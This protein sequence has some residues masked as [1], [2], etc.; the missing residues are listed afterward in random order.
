MEFYWPGKN[1]SYQAH[2]R[3]PNKKSY[4][5]GS[6]KTAMEASIYRENYIKKIKFKE[7]EFIK[8]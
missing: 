5:L 7:L 4:Y 2:I 3:H 8:I 1:N 6:F